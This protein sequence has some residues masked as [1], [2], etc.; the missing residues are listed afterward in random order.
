[1]Q[2]CIQIFL[3]TTNN[4]LRS[5]NSFEHTCPVSLSNLYSRN[6]GLFGPSVVRRGVTAGANITHETGRPKTKEQAI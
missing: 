2:T 3:N 6:P 5:L 4:K 1:M